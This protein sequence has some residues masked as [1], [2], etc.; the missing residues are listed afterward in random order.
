MEKRQYQTPSGTIQYRI[1]KVDKDTATLVF[2]PGLTA[3][4]RLFDKQIE[5][6]KYK[7]NVFVWDAPGHAE[8][9]PFELDFTLTDK[10]RWLREILEQENIERPVIVGQSM[11]W[12]MMMTEKC[13][14]G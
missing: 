6:F 3:D 7:Y 2:L 10:A 14:I 13:I 1:N 8:S 12:Y 9:R 11:V 5:Y 4:H